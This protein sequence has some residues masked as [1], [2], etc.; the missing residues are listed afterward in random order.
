MYAP[1]SLVKKA[2][3]AAIYRPG[4]GGSPVEIAQPIVDGRLR[5]DAKPQAVASSYDKAKQRSIKGD[6]SRTWC[7]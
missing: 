4:F 3:V 6:I 1:P 7:R 5:R 2:I